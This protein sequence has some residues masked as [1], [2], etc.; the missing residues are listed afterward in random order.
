MLSTFFVID[1]TV[2]SCDCDLTSFS[3]EVDP[4]DGNRLIAVNCISCGQ[5][6][7]A[8]AIKAAAKEN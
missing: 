7:D 3:V 2:L 8:D 5:R 6:Y 1:A 4:D